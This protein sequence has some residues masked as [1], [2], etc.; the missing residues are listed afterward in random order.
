[1]NI[2]KQS[3]TYIHAEPVHA[4]VQTNSFTLCHIDVLGFNTGKTTS[5]PR[6]VETDLQVSCR[7][8]ARL[9]AAGELRAFVPTLRRLNRKQRAALERFADVMEV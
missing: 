1:M 9:I 2:R 5:Q 4:F 7:S 8:C 6:Y 3:P